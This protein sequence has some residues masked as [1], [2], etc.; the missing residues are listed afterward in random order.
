MNKI[1][2]LSLWL[3]LLKI[4]KKTMLIVDLVVYMCFK[5]KIEH[6]SVNLI[7]ELHFCNSLLRYYVN[8]LLGITAIPVFQNQVHK[9]LT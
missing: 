3:R 6:L 9:M 4:I 7:W 1:N 2:S 8:S 5:I